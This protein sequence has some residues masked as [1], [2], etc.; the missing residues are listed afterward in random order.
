LV[1]IEC[2]D[3]YA[4]GCNKEFRKWKKQFVKEI[5]D[6]IRKKINKYDNM[7]REEAR[8]REIEGERI[9]VNEHSIKKWENQEAS[10]VLRE[11]L[12]IIKQKAGKELGK[13]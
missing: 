9:I 7:A 10:R 4:K 13:K 3:C 6:E 8:L 11:M 1:S 12:E 5:L 2:P